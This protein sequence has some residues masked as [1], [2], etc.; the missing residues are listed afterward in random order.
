MKKF[1]ISWW[2]GMAILVIATTTMGCGSLHADYVAADRET[3]TFAAPK[4]TEWA[5]T[6][7]DEWKG[8]VKNKLTSWE[9]R[10][11]RAEKKLEEEE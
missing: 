7:D 11:E 1:W 6:Q 4:L 2:W 9:A 5:G 10:V 3:Y 8:I